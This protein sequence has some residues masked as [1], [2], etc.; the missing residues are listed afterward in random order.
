MTMTNRAWWFSCSRFTTYCISDNKNIIVKGGPIIG[1]FMGQ[2]V[3]NLVDWMKK[4]GRF[5]YHE[6]DDWPME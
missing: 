6:Y 1:R 5:K 2:H 4:L 3:K